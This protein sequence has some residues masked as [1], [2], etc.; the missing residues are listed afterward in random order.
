MQKFKFKV[1]LTRSFD[2]AEAIIEASTPAEA[3][4]LALDSAQNNDESLTWR[5]RRE[6]LKIEDSQPRVIHC[7]VIPD[8]R[9]VVAVQKHG[10]TF[11]V[12]EHGLVLDRNAALKFTNPPIAE[13]SAAAINNEPLNAGVFT[14]TVIPFV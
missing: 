3:E 10:T 8:I 12:A 4:R 7:E 9:V 11:Y 13:A 6:R 5:E 14:A 1:T 2:Y